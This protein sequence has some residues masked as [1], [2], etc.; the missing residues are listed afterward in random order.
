[1]VKTDIV[2]IIVQIRKH[3]ELSVV[4]VH[5]IMKAGMPPNGHGLVPEY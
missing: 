1:M 3:V 4:I 5:N 2:I